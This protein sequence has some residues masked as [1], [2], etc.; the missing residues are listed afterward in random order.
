[1]SEKTLCRQKSWQ[2]SE[3]AMS[4]MPYLSV[5]ILTASDTDPE[6][7]LAAPWV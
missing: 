5:P 3:P 6:K 1:M 2:I 7:P 4:V